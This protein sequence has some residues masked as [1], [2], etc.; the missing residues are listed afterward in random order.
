M[1]ERIFSGIND[2]V[3]QK[4]TYSIKDV[5]HDEQSLIIIENETDYWI[6][7]SSLKEIQSKTNFYKEAPFHRIYD[8]IIKNHP[9]LFI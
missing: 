4:Y 2:I 5:G 8:W 1:D 7:V 3:K 6:F 9:E